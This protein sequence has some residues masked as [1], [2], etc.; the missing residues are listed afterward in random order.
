L[1][2]RLQGPGYQRREEQVRRSRGGILG[3]IVDPLFG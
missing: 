1:L 3:G 2:P